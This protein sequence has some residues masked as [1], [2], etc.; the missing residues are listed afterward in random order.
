MSEYMSGGYK[1]M[2]SPTYTDS[3]DYSNVNGNIL[4]DAYQR[5]LDIAL[6]LISL[7]SKIMDQ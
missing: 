3:I 2:E 6:S 1:I 4:F 5:I 7:K